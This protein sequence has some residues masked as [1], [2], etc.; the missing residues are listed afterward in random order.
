MKLAILLL[1]ATL[2]IAAPAF[3]AEIHSDYDRGAALTQLKSFRFAEMPRP[4]SDPLAQNEL[5][6]RRL[7]NAIQQNLESLGI[8]QTTTGA[9]FT[10]DYR[11]LIQK[12]LHVT[13]INNGPSPWRRGQAWTDV[14]NEGTL[15]VDF[16]D[17]RTGK[18]VW[19]GSATTTLG[20]PEESEARINRAIKKLIERFAKDQKQQR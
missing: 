7:R 18:L 2:S 17:A 20:H 15:V 11:V 6:D 1:A 12:R 19:R 16:L 5:V 14:V 10:I 9:H 4:A 8:N 3:G 13:T